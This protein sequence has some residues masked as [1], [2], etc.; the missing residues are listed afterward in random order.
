[1]LYLTH[2]SSV[3]VLILPMRITHFVEETAVSHTYQL[4]TNTN[5]TCENLLI[6]LK[7]LQYF[8]H[9]SSVI[10][11]V[12]ITHFVEETAVSHP[13]Q[14]CT[15]TNITCENLLILLKKLQ[16]LIHISS[17]LV[18]ILPVWITH[19]VEETAVSH[20]YQLCTNTNTCTCITCENLLILLEKLLYLKHIS[21]VLV[22]ILPVRINSFCWRNCCI[23]HISASSDSRRAVVSFSQKNVHNTGILLRGLSLPSKKCG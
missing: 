13:Y 7:E 12:W 15:N 9:I 3:L 8:I 6:L 11:P 5:I 17:V 14:L 1:M 4:C 23:S 20:T 18:L 22:L 2:I 19:F 16:Y 21:S 10:L